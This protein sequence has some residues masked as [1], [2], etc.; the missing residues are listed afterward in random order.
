[1]HKNNATVMIIL[2]EIAN[3]VITVFKSGML[4]HHMSHVAHHLAASISDT[5]CVSSSVVKL[6]MPLPQHRHDV[7]ETCMVGGT[8]NAGS[9]SSLGGGSDSCAEGS[10]SVCGWDGD[11][12]CRYGA[13]SAAVLDSITPSTCAGVHTPNSAMSETECL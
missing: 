4:H 10:I 7:D 3:V 12:G 13:C 5:T 8:G 1:M 2:R 9:P 6:S 11:D